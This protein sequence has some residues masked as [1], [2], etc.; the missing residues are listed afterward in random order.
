M[1]IPHRGR[2]GHG[3]YFITASTFQKKQILQAT[4]MADLFLQTLRH[5]QEKGKFLLHEFVIMPDHFH[6][7]ITPIETL[8]RSMQLIKGGFSFR[9]KKELGFGGEVWQNSYYDRRVRDSEEYARF[10]D[11]I[12]NNPV[13]RALVAAPG[14]YSHSSATRIE[15]L[16]AVPPGLKP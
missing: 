8:E 16:S 6:L 4:R 1:G 9:A 11:Y 12:H 13:K 2:T 7:L 5:Y 14:E 3:T 10:R 15:D